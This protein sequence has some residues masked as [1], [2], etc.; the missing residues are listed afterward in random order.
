VRAFFSGEH[1]GDTFVG[2]RQQPLG[3]LRWDIWRFGPCMFA[4][5]AF[6]MP[7]DHSGLRDHPYD[8]GACA[9]AFRAGNRKRMGL[10]TRH[11][12]QYRDASST[13]GSP[14]DR[15]FHSSRA[16]GWKDARK[17]RVW[18]GPSFQAPRHS[19]R[20]V[21]IGDPIV[22]AWNRSR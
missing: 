3:R 4:H 9:V 22:V 8:N 13:T 16:C 18:C 20:R 6:E 10:G 1:L 15:A 21:S 7:L 2:T 11:S 17:N 19:P 14:G 5:P 12:P